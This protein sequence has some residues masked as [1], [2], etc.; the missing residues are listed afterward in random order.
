MILH[1]IN[2]KLRHIKMK[3]NKKVGDARWAAG[4]AESLTIVQV[5]R[6][7]PLKE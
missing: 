7:T 6:K 2:R 1:L 4:Q 5:S 3:T